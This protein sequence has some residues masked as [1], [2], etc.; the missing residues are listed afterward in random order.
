MLLPYAK[1]RK[2]TLDFTSPAAASQ[3]HPGSQFPE[4]LL[5]VWR[6]LHL[7]RIEPSVGFTFRIGA[8]DPRDALG[9][10]ILR[11]FG[12]AALGLVKK[13]WLCAASRCRDINSPARPLAHRDA[14]GIELSCLDQI[15]TACRVIP[16]VSAPA[17]RECA[18]LAPCA[19]GAAVP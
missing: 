16:N 1:A 8:L 7:A 17:A 14:N 4:L 10:F 18:W 11:L 12:I 15:A 9:G 13:I 3:N 19:L 2:G 5:L 6:I